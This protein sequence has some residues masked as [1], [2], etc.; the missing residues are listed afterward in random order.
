MRYALTLV[1]SVLTA[2]PLGA[3][4]RDSHRPAPL[5]WADV[6][7]LASFDPAGGQLV[8][9]R[10]IIDAFVRSDLAAENTSDAQDLVHAQA[11]SLVRVAL[12]SGVTVAELPFG[13]E[14][15]WSLAPFDGKHDFAGASGRSI[16][17]AGRRH[18]EV[19]IDDPGVLL[20]FVGPVGGGGT[21]ELPVSA[22]GMTSILGG[23]KLEQLAGQ[24]AGVRVQV[25]YFAV[26]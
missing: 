20:Y 10:L 14:V 5:P 6:V 13:A 19:L 18:A 24:A 23:M 2:I 25:E 11:A 15:T 7:Q 21:V 1:L 22:D 9:V 26:P 16:R 4:L 17:L 8:G 12:P 3:V